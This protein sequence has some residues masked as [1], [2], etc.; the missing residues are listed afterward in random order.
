M[1]VSKYPNTKCHCCKTK[2]KKVSKALLTCN[3]VICHNC[4]D[5]ILYRNFGDN[6]AIVSID[7]KRLFD[8]S[9]DKEYRKMV[10][11]TK[12][13]SGIIQCPKCNDS[14]SILCATFRE[15]GLPMKIIGIVEFEH[16]GDLITYHLCTSLDLIHMMNMEKQMELLGKY[17]YNST[18]HFNHTE[19]PEIKNYDIH[20]SHYHVVNTDSGYEIQN[21][22]ECEACKGNATHTQ[23]DEYLNKLH[24]S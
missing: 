1:S 17:D 7:K 16:H 20:H 23:F 13:T 6:L 4:I 9:C 19:I 24:P 15:Y 5:N 18:D 11:G 2:N 8:E 21:K 14:Y 3:H 12:D 10:L 22:D